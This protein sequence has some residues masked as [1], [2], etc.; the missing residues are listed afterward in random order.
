MHKE[1]IVLWLYAVCNSSL[2]VPFRNWKYEASGRDE[3]GIE[4]IMGIRR[5]E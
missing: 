4:S 5:V 3:N 2:V 1:C